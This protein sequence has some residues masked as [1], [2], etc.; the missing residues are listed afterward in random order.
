M[1]ASR[2]AS[3]TPKPPAC[4][5]CPATI[6]SRPTPPGWKSSGR[7]RPGRL[8]PTDRIHPRSRASPLRDPRLPL[9]GPARRSH[10]TRGAANY[11]CASIP[12]GAGPAPSPPPG[13][14]CEP[15]S[16]TAK[17]APTTTNPKDPGPQERPPT[18]A[19][20]AGRTHPKSKRQLL[21]DFQGIEP[22]DPT[23]TKIRA[24]NRYGCH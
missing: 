12:P 6:L 9:P 5:T 13:S 20:R 19:T 14:A 2:T 4:A 24:K 21:N 3:G 1:P 15:P 16:L 17:P 8:G 11:G 10:I 7:R 23:G 22:P 18:P